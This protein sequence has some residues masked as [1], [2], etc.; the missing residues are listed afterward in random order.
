MAIRVLRKWGNLG[1]KVARHS[2][3]TSKDSVSESVVKSS[4]SAMRCKWSLLSWL[5]CTVLQGG[6]SFPMTTFVIWPDELLCIC[7]CM[8]TCMCRR[9]SSLLLNTLWDRVCSS[10][11][12]CT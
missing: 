8:C 6:V 2:C 10:D 3:Y 9:I 11:S 5:P 4:H 12:G 7:T 1:V